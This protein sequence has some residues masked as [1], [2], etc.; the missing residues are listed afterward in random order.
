LEI[1]SASTDSIFPTFVGAPR[2]DDGV[3]DDSIWF[4]REEGFIRNR[5][6]RTRRTANS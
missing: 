1:L 2:I 6:T 3:N 4:D 5:L